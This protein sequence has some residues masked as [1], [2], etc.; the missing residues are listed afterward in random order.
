M[1]FH[2]FY[3]PKFVGDVLLV[4][5]GEGKTNSYITNG[6]VTVLKDEQGEIIG[7]NIFHA[8]IYF[9]ELTTGL[10]KVTKQL[11][12]ECNVI[13]DTF[14]L[15]HVTSDFKDTFVVGKV[16][17]MENHPDSDHLHVC[18]VE[19]KDMI[20]QIVC[21][22]SN[23]AK[24]QLVVVASIGAVMPSGLII[25]PSMLRKVAS[26]GM[27]CSARELQLTRGFNTTGIIVLDENTYQIGQSFL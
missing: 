13:L 3:N 15:P 23:V 19:L 9:T 20:T 14:G 7:Y 26:N 18:Q 8:S 22:A 24:G 25:K 6:D 2:A 12:E 10:V 17:A 4:R 11:V 27:L 21:G 1:I 16:I 5:L